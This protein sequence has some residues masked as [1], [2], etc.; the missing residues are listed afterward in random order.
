MQNPSEIIEE[1]TIDR[2]YGPHIGCC[3]WFNKKL[4]YGFITVY[5]GE[6]KGSNIFVH[7]SGVHPLNSNFKT[8]KKGEYVSLDIIDGKNGTQAI[9]VKG[10][11]GGPLMCDQIEY[12]VKGKFN[13]SA[14]V[15]LQA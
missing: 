9:E 14:P 10:I 13:S 11:L 5:D 8:L 6:H 3:K 4:G 7:H 15:T 2:E 1:V 12:S